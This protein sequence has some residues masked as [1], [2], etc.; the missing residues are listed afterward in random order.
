MS[1]IAAIL[2]VALSLT[3]PADYTYTTPFCSS[4]QIVGVGMG[5]NG[6]YT[7]LRAE[8]V[9]FLREAYAERTDVPFAF[10][11]D[12]TNAIDRLIPIRPWNANSKVFWE[13]DIGKCFSLSYT[14]EEK[15]LSRTFT[16]GSFVRSGFRF[17]TTSLQ[18]VEVDAF[19]ERDF[20]EFALLA[21]NAVAQGMAF[22]TNDIPSTWYDRPYVMTKNRIR[23]LYSGLP[24]FNVAAL[25]ARST[26][27][28]SP[29]SIARATVYNDGMFSDVVA[30]YY[31]DTAEYEDEYGRIHTTPYHS[32]YKR[33]RTTETNTE[34]K[35]MGTWLTS[36]VEQRWV[37]MYNEFAVMK[38]GPDGPWPTVVLGNYKGID[39]S[40]RLFMLSNSFAWVESPVKTNAQDSIEILQTVLDLH[41][42]YTV[43][44]SR[45][46]TNPTALPET[47]EESTNIVRR[48]VMWIPSV[49]E[50][51][52]L[53][54]LTY[55][56]RW[57][58]KMEVWTG[59]M[60][61]QAIQLFGGLDDHFPTPAQVED[62]EIA[63][64]ATGGGTASGQTFV[65]VSL[66][67][68]G[69]RIYMVY[70]REF[71]ARTL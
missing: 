62:S 65:E 40:R 44:I 47:R 4:N 56:G 7:M 31:T 19:P 67:F 50:L 41:L 26:Y 14:G 15:P 55:D 5:V 66:N 42:T 38:D 54:G 22:R 13:G 53:S 71:S 16:P 12:D 60:Y 25:E 6:D 10:H 32:G 52:K 37:V 43:R 33:F 21:S 35:T 11:P 46:W 8:D 49:A 45:R 64:E 27:A 2:A 3:K 34:Y 9:A 18:L 17:G 70:Q 68:S 24:L 63:A 28:S 20:D 58:Y 57:K 51:D 36:I 39:N 48:A 61:Q 29:G 23:S 59:R 69:S 30:E 1:M